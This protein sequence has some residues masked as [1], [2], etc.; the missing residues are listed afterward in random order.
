LPV[1]YIIFTLPNLLKTLPPMHLATEGP[2]KTLQ[3]VQVLSSD[4]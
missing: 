3:K 2:T 1:P 4:L